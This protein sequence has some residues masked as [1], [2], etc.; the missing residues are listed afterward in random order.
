M[1]KLTKK[2]V[3]SFN[4]IESDSCLCNGTKY[5]ELSRLVEAR[6]ALKK[7]IDKRQLDWSC[8]SD[9]KSNDVKEL[10][11]DFLLGGEK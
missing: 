11:D 7:E 10:I 3:K 9:E 6:K 1:T 8:G 2:D 4:C 5:I